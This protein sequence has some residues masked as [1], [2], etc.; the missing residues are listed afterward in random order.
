MNEKDNMLWYENLI[1][2]KHI[3]SINNT[4]TCRIGFNRKVISN[5]ITRVIGETVEADASTVIEAIQDARL[6]YEFLTA[7][8]LSAA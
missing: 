7:D 6:Q 8:I 4:V 1:A 5:G 3:E 2:P